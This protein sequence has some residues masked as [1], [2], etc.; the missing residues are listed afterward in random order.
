MTKIEATPQSVTSMDF[1]PLTLGVKGSEPIRAAPPN[2]TAKRKS[3]AMAQILARP[4][5]L[6]SKSP[7]ADVR[8]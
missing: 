8:I 1:H 2:I 3:L 4:G 7:P 5:E 6:C